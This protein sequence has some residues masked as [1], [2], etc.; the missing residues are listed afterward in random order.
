MTGVASAGPRPGAASAIDQAAAMSP[1]R[2]KSALVIVA[3]AFMMDLI[4]LTIVN[5]ALPSIQRD[6]GAGP[7]AM[8]WMVAGYAVAF[9]VLLITGGRLGDTHGYRRLFMVGVAGFTVTSLLCGAAAS[10]ALLVLSRLAQGAAAALMLPQVM[11]LIQVMYPPAERIGAL[12]IFGVLGGLAAVLGPI[13]GGLLI[14]ANLFGLGWRPIFLINGPLG[15]AGLIG[16]WRVLPL[17]RSSRASGVD[18]LG[19]LLIAATL[20][21]VILPLMQGREAGWPWWCLASLALAPFLGLLF[22]RH[23]RRRSTTG[24][25]LVD[26]GLFANRGFTV[27]VCISLCFQVVTAGLLFI[28][29]L[30]LQYGLGCSPLETALV[31]VPYAVGASVA[32]GVVAR[33][34][35]PRIGLRLIGIGVVI[36]FAGLVV[37]FALISAQAPLMA[38]GGALLVTGT[39]MG[40]TGGPL[41]PVTLSDVDVAHAGAASG[42]MKAVQQLGAASGA[43]LI[44]SLYFALARDLD[45][46][47]ARRSFL[48]TLPLV[49]GLLLVVGGLVTRLPKDLRIFSKT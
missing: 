15:V 11:S 9:A 33:R 25:A 26:P 46:D 8:Q 4:D 48:A 31:H 34:A 43:A 1:G 2:R 6:L 39:G 5:V 19:T 36:M 29:T 13:L 3:G 35:L 45:P 22:M 30:T 47:H 18:V 10:P 44:G 42:T 23:I 14:E 40:L 17:G 28:L 38:I 21:A 41:G 32:I 16:A 49:A 37:L 12:A 7:A 27:G 20:L 24:T